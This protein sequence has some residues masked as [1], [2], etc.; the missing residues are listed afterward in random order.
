VSRLFKTFLVGIFLGIA[1]AGALAYS[2]PVVDLHREVSLISVR[3]NGGNAETFRINLPRD[4]IMVGLAGSE[5]ALPAGLEWPDESL[6]GNLQAEMFKVRDRNNVVIGVASRMASASEQT[7]PFI[8]WVLHLPA[9][10]TLYLD[11]ELA[12]TA[13][14]FRNGSLTTGTR[15]FENLSGNIREQFI[16]NDESNEFDGT[17]RIEL[18]TFFVAPLGSEPDMDSESAA[19]GQQ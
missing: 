10:G 19:G 14:G 2:V 8:E 9:R 1:G 17:G 7:G 15:D 3:A 13:E 4:R 12:P 16:S 5:G 18:L 6:L 11:M